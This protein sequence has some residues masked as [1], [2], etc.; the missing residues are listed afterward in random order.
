M[1]SI[2]VHGGAGSVP[3]KDH[4]KAKEGVKKAV[5]K[6]EKVLKEGKTSL[7]AVEKAINVLEND[8]QFNAGTGS[9]INV[10]KEVEMDASIM[11]SE[12]DVGGLASIK[13]VKNP[14]SVSRKIMEKTDHVLLSGEGAKEFARAMGFEEYDPKTKQRI[15]EWESLKKD[16]KENKSEKYQKISDLA[17]NNPGLVLGTVGAVAIDKNGLI[18]AGTSTGGL[19]MKMKGRIGDTPLIGC[20]TYA[21][22]NGGVSATGIGE[23][24]IRLVLAKKVNDIIQKG[25]DAKTATKEAIE[26]GKKLKEEY[27]SL[28]VISIDKN[29][30]IGFNNNTENMSVAY[31][32]KEY[33]EPKTSI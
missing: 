18:T 11:T 3:E 24:I 12:L 5:L 28:G 17:E 22:H 26:Y 33:K 8:P 21:D 4:S 23:G 29:G 1:Y 15:E 6:G 7:D 27:N 20:G 14:I 10:N 13:K 9:V 31:T 32:K 30:N 2:I 25:K 19:N 16:I